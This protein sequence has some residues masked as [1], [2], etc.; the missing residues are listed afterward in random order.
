M[1]ET[2][3]GFIAVVGRPNAGKSTLLNH[4]VGERVAMVSKKAQATRKRMNM[5]VMHENAQ[6]IFVDT[7]G[8]HHKEKLIN[9]FMLEEALKAMGDSDLIIF[10]AP[11]SDNTKE[12]EKFLDLTESKNSKHIIILTKIDQVPQAKLLET[13][14]SYQPFSDKFEAIIPFSVNKS[15]GKKDLLNVVSRY[16]PLSPFLFDTDILTTEHIRSIYK[17]LIRESIF[18][19]MSDEIPYESDVIIDKVHEDEDIDRVEATIVVEK[20][21]QKRMIVGKGGEAIKRIGI[22]ARKIM[23]QFAQKKIHLELIVVVKAGWSKNKIELESFGYI[24]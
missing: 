2:K 14:H 20:E 12:Y 4:L 22:G 24:F 15:V 17:E 8:I 7:P 13:L 21:V 11:A 23:E 18:E 1:Q 3:A 10:L 5:I 19:N 6:L 9:Q 16:L